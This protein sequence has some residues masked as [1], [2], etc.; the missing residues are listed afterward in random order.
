M[1]ALKA[2]TYIAGHNDPLT[3]RDLQ[4]LATSIE[5]KQSRVKAMIADGKSLD[6][7]RKEFGIAPATPGRS[8][9]RSLV[10]V[11]Y[12]ELTEKK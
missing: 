5:E 7:I 1:V 6:D 3:S 10:E 2:D 12:L 4:A 11:I 9:F 8:G